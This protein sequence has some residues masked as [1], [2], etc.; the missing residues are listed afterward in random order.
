[1]AEVSFLKVSLD[2]ELVASATLEVYD[3]KKAW[4]TFVN[5]Y[6]TIAHLVSGELFGTM[7]A[8]CDDEV[9]LRTPETGLT[10]DLSTG[11]RPTIYVPENGHSPKGF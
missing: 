4:Q 10:I 5:C 8:A 6:P 7:Q 9:R 1:M 3:Q 2:G 11:V